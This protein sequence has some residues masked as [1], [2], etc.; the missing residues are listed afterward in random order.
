MTI[1]RPVETRD[2]PG[3]R[4]ALVEAW[5]AT[6]DPL[7]GAERVSALTNAWHSQR[8]LA[9]ELGDPECVFLLAEDAGRVVA[10]STAKAEP[11]GAVKLTRLYLVP[12]VQGRGLGKRL[13]NETLARFGR[14]AVWLTAHSGNTGAIGFY[15]HHGFVLTGM[16]DDDAEGVVMRR[17]LGF[18]ARPVRDEDA[19]DLFGLLTLCF[20]EYP[21]C[22]TDPHDDLRDILQPATR[23]REAGARFWAVDD[24][25]GRICACVSVDFPSE[26]TGELHRL[27]VR[28]DMRRSG[29]G[30]GLVGIVEAEA[31]RQ[32]ARRI[33]F[34]SDTRFTNAHRLYERMGYSRH[35]GERDLGD[36]SNSREYFFE[37]ALDQGGAS[38]DRRASARKP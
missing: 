21:G 17:P 31:R 27:Y 6:Y 9:R 4:E 29:L 33:V 20:A 25:R 34:W 13:M 35:P 30:A 16:S 23:A 7:I 1:I 2:L 38:G 11:N 37:K 12:S 24:E 8:A 3:V 26:G 15:R 19:Q 14:T 28:P 32:G 22:Y 10:V 5:H 36:I 18:P